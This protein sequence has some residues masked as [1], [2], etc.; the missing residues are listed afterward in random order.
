M[1]LIIIHG[2]GLIAISQK[3]LEIKKRFAPLLVTEISGKNLSFDQ[4]LVELATLSLF[5]PD[6]LVILEEFDDKIDLTK[7][8]QQAELTV[9]I[10][11]NKAVSPATIKKA[12]ELK[13]QILSFTEKDETSI[14]PFLD[15][16]AE[17]NQQ[18]LLEI[19]KL[20][21]QYGGQY[22]LTMIFYMLRRMIILSKNLPPF[23]VKKITR[24]SQNFPPE[25]ISQLYKE[26]LEID[27]KIKTG[28]IEEKMAVTLLINKI[29]TC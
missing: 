7:I 14:F 5:A 22:I 6:R 24:Q 28:R 26:A 4:A 8:P 15:K 2:N 13:F 29:L 25:K 12:Q 1:S 18:T 11:Y 27:F 9:V 23:V 17:K 3:V 21:N 10:K 16:L 20:L 19:D